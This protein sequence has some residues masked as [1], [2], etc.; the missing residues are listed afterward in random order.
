MD[1]CA[2]AEFYGTASAPYLSEPDIEGPGPNL[3]HSGA[4]RR[5]IGSLA[6]RLGYVTP[7]QAWARGFGSPLHEG[8]TSESRLFIAVTETSGVAPS[9]PERMPIAG[10]DWC[11][12]V[13]AAI[14]YEGNLQ[15]SLFLD[16]SERQSPGNRGSGQSRMHPSRRAPRRTGKLRQYNS[17]YRAKPSWYLQVGTQL[18]AINPRLSQLHIGAILIAATWVVTKQKASDLHV[19][20]AQVTAP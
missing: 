6:Q 10:G 4:A 18:N 14:R 11:L 13:C 9:R 20:I 12:Q 15:G 3:V 16:S 17:C 8:G 1:P 2:R 7:I 19:L 5:H